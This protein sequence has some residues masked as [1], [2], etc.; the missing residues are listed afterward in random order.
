MMD[1]NRSETKGLF[2]TVS[3]EWEE[4]AIQAKIQLLLQ[5]NVN[6][7]GYEYTGFGRDRWKS[8]VKQ[9]HFSNIFLTTKT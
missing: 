5:E 7:N 4:N 2:S 8:F 9:E 6:I 1:T 3:W